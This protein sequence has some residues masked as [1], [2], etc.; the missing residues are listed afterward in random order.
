MREK[1]V[2]KLYKNG[3]TNII[4]QEEITRGRNKMC[5]EIEHRNT[6]DYQ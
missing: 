1:I 5:S 4:S 2:Q 6:K 3:Y